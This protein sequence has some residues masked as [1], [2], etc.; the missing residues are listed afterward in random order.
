MNLRIASAKVCANKGAAGVDKVTVETW[1]SKE[2]AHVRQL[3][4][5]L[6]ANTYCSQPVR[7][8][9]IDKPGTNKQRPLGIPTLTDRVCQQAVLQVLQPTFEEIFFEGSHGFRPGRST[10][11]AKEA[12]LQYKKAGHRY[13]DCPEK[14]GL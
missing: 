14:V 13:V 9:Y 10:H 11:T 3:H 2:E 8:V 6:Y 12:I 4:G 7:R 5:E 1:R